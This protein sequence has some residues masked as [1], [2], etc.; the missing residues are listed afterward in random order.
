MEQTVDAMMT[1]ALWT[2]QDDASV[3]EAAQTMRDADIGDVIVLG[4][5]GAVAGIITDRDLVVR[6]VAKGLDPRTEPVS[7]FYSE[8]VVSVGPAEAVDSALE[9]MREHKIRRL[10]VIDDSD[11]LVGIVS[12]GDVAADMQPT[13]ALAD[14]SQAPPNN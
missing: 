10:P 5:D 3:Q 7:N 14:I 6:V 1:T 11:R 12:L 9:L 2:V 4:E 13:S 8:D